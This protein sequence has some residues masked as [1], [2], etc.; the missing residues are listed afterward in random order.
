MQAAARFRAGALALR[1]G[2]CTLPRGALVSLILL[3]VPAQP[4]HKLARYIQG[5]A[6]CAIEV[7]IEVRLVM[8]HENVL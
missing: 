6:G 1:A 4:G 7:V 8:R 3:V 2:S 5:G